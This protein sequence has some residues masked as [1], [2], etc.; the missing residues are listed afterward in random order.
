MNSRI[1][2][3]PEY[4]ERLRANREW[5]RA[6]RTTLLEGLRVAAVALTTVANESTDER[7]RNF[8]KIHAEQARRAMKEAGENEPRD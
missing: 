6:K 7:I 8:A 5:L 3:S 4:V 1:S 2:F